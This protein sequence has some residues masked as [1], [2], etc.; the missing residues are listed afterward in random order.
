MTI[1]K[2]H[3]GHVGVV[4][5]V[6]MSQPVVRFVKSALVLGNVGLNGLLMWKDDNV[7]AP[8]F[9]STAEALCFVKRL[10]NFFMSISHLV[11]SFVPIMTQC[12]ASGFSALT[13]YGGCCTARTVSEETKK[14]SPIISAANV[15][16]IP[17]GEMV[18]T[19]S[20]SSSFY[21]SVRTKFSKKL[22][23]D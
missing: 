8:V 21:G 17:R 19:F 7:F 23:G 20:F 14:N 18:D 12:P 2:Y 5:F 11:F 10:A 1:S 6:N 4:T 3:L 9:Q 22:N 13:G 16:F 15:S